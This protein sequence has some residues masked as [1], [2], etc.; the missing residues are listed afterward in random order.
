DRCVL[1]ARVESMG[2]E[3]AVSVLASVSLSQPIDRVPSPSRHRARFYLTVTAI[4]LAAA[5]GGLVGSS[6]VDFAQL[7]DGCGSSGDCAPESWAGARMRER[8]GYAILGVGGAIAATSLILWLLE[9]REGP[10]FS[11]RVGV[12]ATGAATGLAIE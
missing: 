7:H 8:T 10:P 11:H 12:A 2:D 9:R 3:E 6:V 1:V 4:A 5:G